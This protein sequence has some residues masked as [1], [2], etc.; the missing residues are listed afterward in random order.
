LATT[1]PGDY[2]VVYLAIGSMT[3]SGDDTDSS[4]DAFADEFHQFRSLYTHPLL[5]KFPDF[6]MKVIMEDT[7][8]VTS[9]QYDI[10][11]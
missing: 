5:S 7:V 11:P 3:S 10:W 8:T 6:V 2:N 4:S 1:S 9:Q